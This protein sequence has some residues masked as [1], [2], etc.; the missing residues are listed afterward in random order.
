MLNQNLAEFYGID[1]VEGVSFRPV[2][3]ELSKGRGGL[4]SHGSFL[5]GHSDG[6]EPHPIKRAVWVKEKLLGQ[7]PLPPPP[8]V[9]D[10]DP[11]T[12]GFDKLTL[13]EQIELHRDT[14]SCRDC[15][16]SFDP[17]GIALES[18]NAVG[19]LES[20]RKGRPI[21]ASTVLPDGT[22][23]EGPAGLRSYILE[24]VPDSFADSLIEHLFAYALG[25][26]V[27]YADEEEL[28]NIRKAVRSR[29][30]KMRAVIHEIV[31]SPSFLE[32]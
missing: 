24:D 27:S 14:D 22:E 11:A 21:D 18:Y 10:L 32:R 16:A 6:N 28:Q 15:H 8:N 5:A 3:V 31:R 9:P 1:E 30:D 23:I 29:D 2:S 17:Y 7:P 26:D 13:K 19:L 25:R 12:P 4:L 20:A